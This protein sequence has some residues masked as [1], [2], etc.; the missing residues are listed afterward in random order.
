MGEGVYPR[1]L[2]EIVERLRARKWSYSA[3]PFE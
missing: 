1:Q 3:L 2:L